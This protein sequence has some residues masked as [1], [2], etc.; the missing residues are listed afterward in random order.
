MLAATSRSAGMSPTWGKSG[1]RLIRSADVRPLVR[2]KGKST[3][4]LQE[5]IRG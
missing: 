3:T 4:E 1:G 5:A 2:V